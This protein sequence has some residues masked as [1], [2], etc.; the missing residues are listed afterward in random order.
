MTLLNPSG[1]IMAD[2]ETIFFSKLRL[3]I[4]LGECLVNI[5]FKSEEKIKVTF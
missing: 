5:V 4:S 3:K 2:H 1:V